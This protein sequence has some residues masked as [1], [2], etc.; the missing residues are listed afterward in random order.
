MEGYLTFPGPLPEGVWD[1]VV[2][3]PGKDQA[4]RKWLLFM[5]LTALL[6]LIQTTEECQ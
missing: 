4:L 6:L 1:I 5:A 3:T 2:S